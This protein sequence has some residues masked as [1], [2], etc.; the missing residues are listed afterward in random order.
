MKK[1][2]LLLL[3]SFMT[4]FMGAQAQINPQFIGRYSTGIYDK[5]A[6]EI[7]AYDEVSKRMF[8]TN[9]PDTTIRVVDISKPANPVQINTISIKPYGI[10]LTSVACM[11]GVLAATV[12]NNLGKT[13]NGHVV[14][15]NASTLAFISKV[16]VGANPDML[17][18]S[19]NGK[20]VLVANEGEPN[21]DYT[22]D[23][24]G[25]ISIIDISKGIATLTQNDVKTAGFTDFNGTSIDWKIKITGK[26]HSGGTFLRNSTIAEDLEPEYITVSD[27]SKTAWATCQENNC[28]A[29]ID[30][31]TAK[32]T[33][34]IPLGFKNH[35]LTG[36]GLDASDNGATINIR[37]FPVFGMYMPDA[38]ASYKIGD[39]TFLVTAN[40]G[41]ARADWGAA[42]NEEIRFG[43]AA[44]VVDTAKFG[45][46]TNVGALKALTSMGRLNLTRAFGD[47]N[48]DG[49]YDSAFCYGARSFSVWNSVTGKNWH[50]IVRI[51]LSKNWQ[52]YILPTLM[53]VI[54]AI[55]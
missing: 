33:K 35:N 31:T 37:N 9:G 1:T 42:N 46:A 47:F 36:N 6:A 54:R 16:D 45:G 13:E 38:I 2:K 27:D 21:S 4:A 18:F 43:N 25:S 40:E 29:E 11:N 8:V 32:V 19:P 30:L 26:I 10:D 55:Q 3:L 23:K 14:F 5:A 51:N 44:Y 49:K 50:G 48:K 12:I 7:S 52:Y 41:D 34:L 53:Q 17:T 15:F 22:I 39:T 20:M 28:I 24:E